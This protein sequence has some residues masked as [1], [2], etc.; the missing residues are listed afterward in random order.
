MS[1]EVSEGGAYAVLYTVLGLFTIIAFIASGL[2][3]TSPVWE[4]LGCIML[5]STGA[6]KG[7]GRGGR[8]MLNRAE[9]VRMTKTADFFLAARNSAGWLSIALSFF[10]SGMVRH[11]LMSASAGCHRPHLAI[12]LFRPQTIVFTNNIH[13][14]LLSVQGAWVVYGSTEM[15]ANP[16]LSWLGVLGYSAASGFP[17]LIICIIG[18]RVREITGEKRAFATSD[19]GRERYGRIMQLSIAAISVFYSE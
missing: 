14:S 9:S 16:N 1:F 10:A 8:P 11:G 13:S 3:G 12:F 6:I 7:G 18:P 2:L 5:P 17:A 19:F 4:K 15:G